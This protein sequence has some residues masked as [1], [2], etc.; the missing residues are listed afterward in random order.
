MR[1]NIYTEWRV[2]AMGRNIQ[3]K[4]DQD[5]DTYKNHR[6]K[7]H[8]RFFIEFIAPLHEFVEQM[9]FRI[10]TCRDVI[11][12]NERN[13]DKQQYIV[14][15]TRQRHGHFRMT[16]MFRI[17]RVSQRNKRIKNDKGKQQVQ[18]RFFQ[19]EQEIILRFHI[20][21]YHLFFRTVICPPG[22]DFLFLFGS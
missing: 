13:H 16:M 6:G 10:F 14:K 9:G 4:R 20:Y 15:Q 17:R 7:Q 8:E 12:R 2:F 11:I 1:Y 3:C 21:I 5:K 22:F 18:M 19:H